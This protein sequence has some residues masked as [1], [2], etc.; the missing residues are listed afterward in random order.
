MPHSYAAEFPAGIQVDESIKRYFEEFY[1]TSDTPDAHERYTDSFTK[2]ATVVIGSKKAVGRDEILKFR[3]GMWT[4]VAARLHSPI[5]IFPFGP[6]ANE[7]M[8]YGTLT[9]TMKDDRKVNL[10]WAGRANLVNES[11]NWKM[12]FY[13]VYVDTAATANAK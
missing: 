11:G 9:Y 10:E 12:S 2:D 3:K 13:Q 8:L 7:V 6:N 5:K 4:A 1:K